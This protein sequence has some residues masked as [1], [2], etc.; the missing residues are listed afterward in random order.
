MKR[1]FEMKKLLMILAIMAVAS[2]ANAQLVITGVFDGPLTGGLP[3]FVELYACD[4]IADLSIY[5]LGC[6]NNG[7]GTDGVEFIFPA[8]SV[9]G[10]TFI[11]CTDGDGTS[12]ATYM[13]FA[14]DY[15]AGQAAGTNGDDAIELF[16]VDGADPVV[17]DVHGD[18]NADGTGLPWDYLDGWS[19]RVTAT[20]PDG[21]TFVI[22]NWIFSGPN[23]TDGCT[24]NTSCNSVFP[25]GGYDCD[26]AVSTEDASWGTIKTLYR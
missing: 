18:I 12:F 21:S 15:D 9:A 17:V 7:G 10:G 2:A 23:A 8:D 4:D 14:S 5:G 16:L 13:G 11:Y 3:K 1:E 20:G 6:A 26:P 22:G 24:T 25:V 19:K